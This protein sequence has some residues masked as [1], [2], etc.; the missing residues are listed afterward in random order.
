MSASSVDTLQ[1]KYLAFVSNR[2]LMSAWFGCYMTE[3]KEPALLIPLT[4]EQV[5]SELRTHQEDN[6]VFWLALATR[7]LY[8][9][10]VDA[11][12]CFL[13]GQVLE[14]EFN[15]LKMIEQLC[16]NRNVAAKIVFDQ[17]E[18]I[19]LIE[20]LLLTGAIHSC[21]PACGQSCEYSR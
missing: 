3:L 10:E 2:A 13:N 5:N 14:V 12:R 6:K 16:K 11:H 1:E 17:P 15:Q 8:Q 20:S 18:N 21:S 4:Q 7:M 9:A 19:A